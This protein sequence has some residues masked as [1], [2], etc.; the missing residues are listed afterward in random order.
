MIIVRLELRL[1]QASL[2]ISLALYLARRTRSP[3]TNFCHSDSGKFEMCSEKAEEM[4]TF[5]SV[6][7][8]I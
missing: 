5:F 4:Y 7:K 8:K 2:V 3:I 1:N 6:Q